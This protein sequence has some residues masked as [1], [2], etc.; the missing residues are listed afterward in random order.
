M[1]FNCGKCGWLSLTLCVVF[2]WMF[3]YFF[4]VL[5]EMHVNSWLEIK[6]FKYR[7]F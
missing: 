7:S 6:R 3:S 1:K 5:I 2:N 4:E